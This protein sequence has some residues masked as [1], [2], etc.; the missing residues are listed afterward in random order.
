VTITNPYYEFDPV[1]TA[2]TKA[3]SDAVNTQYA[4]LQNAFDLL[5]GTADALTT[6]TATFAPESGSGNAYVVT[7][8]DTR[9]SQQD[10]DEIVFFAT[11]AN[12]GAATLNVDG[13]G[14]TSLVSPDGNALASGD[15]INGIVY[16]VRYDATNTRYQLV[17][18]L[19]NSDA[20][21]AASA[22]AALVSENNAAADATEAMQWATH[23]EDDDVDS[24]PGQFSAFHWAQKA[25]AAASNVLISGTPV[26]DQITVWT[27]ADT[28]EGTTGLT[29]DG[30]A[31]GVTGNI[32][33]TGTVDGIDIATDVAAN[34]AKVT[35]ATHTGQVTGATALALD[36][37][38]VTDQ[39]AAGVLVG[40]DT[41]I[42]ND[43]GVLSEATMDQVATFTGGGGTVTSTSVVTANGVSGSV[44]TATTTPAITLTLGAITPT[45]VNGITLTTGGVATNFLNETGVYSTPAG[46]GNVSNVAT[47]LNNQIGV[48]TAATSLEGTTGLTYDGSTL[49]V[50]GNISVTGTVDGIDIATDVAANTSK[51]TNAT[52][53]GQVTGATALTLDVTAVTDQPAAGT[54]VGTDTIILNDGGV[55]SEATMTQVATFVGGGNVSNTGTPLNDQIG[56]WTNATTQEGTT[57]LTYNGTV[58]DVTGGLTVDNGAATV[59]VTALSTPTRGQIDNAARVSG[60]MYM[61]EQASADTD[62]TGDGQ[63]WVKND[64]PNRLFYT[65][66]GGTDYPVA[67]ATLA[68]AGS[69]LSL[70]ASHN[71]NTAGNFAA[72]F[73][74]HHDD[75]GNDTITL[76]D[77]TSTTNWPLYTS[78]QVINP[79]SGTVTIT[80]GSGTTL[81]DDTG[82][83]TVGGI[84][85]TGGVIT[86]WRSKTTDYIMWGSG[87]A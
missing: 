45:T 67:L 75:G 29:Y 77:S 14:A 60:S 9:T 22:A 18:P 82:T 38:A 41:F 35:N 87:W 39:P 28:I 23:P 8:T 81:F 65:D 85:L 16:V 54:L 30:S 72:N 47:P 64:T 43:G 40:T 24:S 50:T 15:I 42:L 10:G 55:L 48:W 4:A 2:G 83:D 74:S 7:M 19:A 6:G 71:F 49:A 36:V 52:H 32:T 53:T 20:A 59:T 69:A 13:L 21:A 3:R 66:D 51:V 86:I 37:T 56:V 79:G 58:L 63:V 80:E 25:L 44:A 73:V 84:T 26:N 70:N 76:E 33:V 12:T 78:I 27:S 46:G 17:S 57:G 11:H 68:T 62:V 61:L 34:T 5:P 1:F 31:L